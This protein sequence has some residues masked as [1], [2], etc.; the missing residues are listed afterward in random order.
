MKPRLWEFKINVKA[1]RELFKEFE[2]GDD[3]H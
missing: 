2:Y 3:M 1:A